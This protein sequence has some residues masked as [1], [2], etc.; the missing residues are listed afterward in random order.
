MTSRARYVDSSTDITASA[1]ALDGIDSEPVRN[2]PSNLYNFAT[3]Q[4]E[5]SLNFAP[6]QSIKSKAH[7][8]FR[9]AQRSCSVSDKARTNTRSRV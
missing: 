7:S 1:V 2:S 9:V 5:R 3:A 4:S 8:G 6:N